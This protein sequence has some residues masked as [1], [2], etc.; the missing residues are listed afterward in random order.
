MKQCCSNSLLFLG[1]L[2]ISAIFLL[3][4]IGK[5]IAYDENVQYMASKGL[6]FI[7]VL[8]VGAALVEILASL[9]LIL[10]VK[11]RYAALALFLFLI[12][13]TLIF[14]NFWNIADPLVSKIEFI[15]FM[16]NLSI[17]GGL[18]YVMGAGPG[19][20]AIE[21]CCCSRACEVDDSLAS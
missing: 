13:T 5:F 16:K 18:L 20:F 4:G 10:G 19:A 2:A 17:M 1:R 9:A 6:K 15:M 11:T 8:L 12:P 14:H 7:P 21:N 3:S